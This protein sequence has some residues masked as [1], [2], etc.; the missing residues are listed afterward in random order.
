M[1]KYETV[2][3]ECKTCGKPFKLYPREIAFFEKHKLELPKRCK[4][5]RE[6][7]KKSDR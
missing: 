2:S 5:C 4:E 1:N 6:K 3:A 7:R